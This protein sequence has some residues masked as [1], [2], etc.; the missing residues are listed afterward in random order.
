MQVTAFAYGSAARRAPELREEGRAR[1]VC[2]PALEVDGDP[3]CGPH[4]PAPLCRPPAPARRLQDAVSQTTAGASLLGHPRPGKA[5][6]GPVL[7]F[8]QT[9]RRVPGGGRDWP[10]TS[11]SARGAGLAPAAAACCE[12]WLSARQCPDPGVQ[13]V[14]EGSLPSMCHTEPA[15]L[16]G[17]REDT[18]SLGDGLVVWQE[19]PQARLDPS[20]GGAPCRPA[21]LPPWAQGALGCGTQGSKSEGRA[22]AGQT[23]EPSPVRRR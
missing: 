14:T 15:P 23:R 20:V 4:R 2:P 17:P 9:A 19:A 3:V 6:R 10:E 21:E 12:V 8:P 13:A 5:I 1:A 16:R 18:V 11:V 7:T 22:P